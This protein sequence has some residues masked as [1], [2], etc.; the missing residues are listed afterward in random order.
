MVLGGRLHWDGEMHTKIM[1]YRAGDI[2]RTNMKYRAG[3][4]QRTNMNELLS[5]RT[6]THGALSDS[7]RHGAGEVQ[8]NR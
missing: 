7:T 5:D 2:Q 6:S 1:K 8:L 3:D 4:I